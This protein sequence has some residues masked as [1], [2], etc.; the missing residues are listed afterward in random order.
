[1]RRTLLKAA[2][3]LTITAFHMNLLHFL[4]LAEEYNG[5]P[6][7][8]LATDVEAKMWEIFDR[9]PDFPH[10]RLGLPFPTRESLSTI[11]P[12]RSE[13]SFVS[14]YAVRPAFLAEA[15]SPEQ[16]ER[17]RGKRGI[18]PSA[19]VALVMSG[20]GVQAVPWP[21]QLA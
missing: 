3:D 8:H 7:L 4:E 20:G 2:P 12:V 9:P 14:G 13:Q 6:L 5:V 11:T 1:M 18:S 17:E 21:A 10:F 16:R 15:M 19:Q